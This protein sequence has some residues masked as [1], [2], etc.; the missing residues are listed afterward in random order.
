M[1]PSLLLLL[2]L[3]GG[4]A[5]A[6]SPPPAPA[7]FAALAADPYWHRLVH[8]RPRRLLPGVKS[9]IDSEDFFLAPGGKTDPQAE[10]LATVQAFRDGVESRGE[11]VACRFRARF[12][13]LRE[14]LG[15]F[16]PRP[17]CALY[18]G[19]IA[20]REPA[21]AHL[22]FA[23]SDLGGPATMYGH[24][25]LRVDPAGTEDPLL[26]VAISYA[27]T[28]APGVDAFSYAARGLGGGFIGEFS[29]MPY[30]QKVRE[31]ARIDERDI[32]EYPLHLTADEI[33]RVLWHL[34]ELRGTGSDY[35]FLSENCSYMLLALL[36]TARPGLSLSAEFDDPAPY[37]IPID[38]V[39]V[40]RE[41]GLAGE[42]AYRPSQ[43]RRLDAHLAQLP[44]EA[45][46]WALAFATGASTLEDPRLPSEPVARAR[47]LE[48]A[49]EYLSVT[50][51][52]RTQ[53]E[54]FALSRPLLLERSR[55]AASAGFVEPARPP[56]PD[57]G[58][59]SSRLDLG[60]RHSDDRSAAVLRA[61]GAY[62]DR[63]DP[64]AGYLPGAELEFFSAE[65]LARAGTVRVADVSLVNIK[66]VAPWRPGFRPF[67]WQAAFG[68]RRYGLDALAADP[69]QRLG[70]YVEGG[71][72]IAFAPLENVYVHAVAIGMLDA[73]RD[74]R[75][76][77]ALAAGARAGLVFQPASG[78][79]QQLEV[80]ALGDV[81]GAASSRRAL[82]AGA[83]APLGARDGLRLSLQALD[84]GSQHETGA[85]LKWLRYF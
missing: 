79:S 64:A 38:T 11:P 52:P 18:D 40:L 9:V 8:Y 1:I 29:L 4:A 31:Y 23:S 16:A 56:E 51:R 5:A 73:N 54:A 67:T 48:T 3:S 21:R 50:A 25:L 32:W 22:V 75:D 15:D 39:R 26:S 76:G 55:I 69:R 28:V 53:A 42:P 37:T 57:R 6:E 2:T 72:G 49:N 30:H 70:G 35:Y 62:H 61:R 85:E 80:E 45:R 65:L 10:L 66:A 74:L 13:W 24:T 41:Q 7:D 81:A 63:L 34:W 68:A 71:G 17:D 82:R 83:H 36:D 19:W 58:H 12:E 44:A 78:W 59:E 20:A 14:R 47:A 27:A 43:V 33:R 46:D 84:I 60:V 77:Y